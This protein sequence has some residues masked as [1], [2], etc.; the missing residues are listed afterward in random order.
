MA[1]DRIIAENI[2]TT[3]PEQVI[4]TYT[5]QLR[6]LARSRIQGVLQRRIDA[7]DILQSV[8]RSFFQRYDDDRLQQ[9][10]RAVIEPASWKS[11][12]VKSIERM[13]DVGGEY[14]ERI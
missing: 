12:S 5:K 9:Q 1:R 2:A 14:A 4:Q 3:W 8:F 6:Q 7:D 13:L 10:A 11:M